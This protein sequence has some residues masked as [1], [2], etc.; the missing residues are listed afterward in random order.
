MEHS[1]STGLSIRAFA[2]LD[3]CT[4]TT[5]RR[6]ISGGKLPVFADGTI[7]ARHAGGEWRQQNR[8][9]EGGTS[10]G[11]KGGTSHAPRSTV[12]AAA[13]PGGEVFAEEADRFLNDVLAGRY[14]TLA[15]AERVKENALAA[16]H[17]L[18]ARRESGELVELEMAEAALFET[19]RTMRDAWLN[20]PVRV[21]PLIAAALGISADALAT[22]MS[23]HVHQQIADLGEP[24]GSEFRDDA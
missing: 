8:R 22:Q 5:V 4:H 3:G 13:D 19:T 11:T 16:K 17:L 15:E 9:A 1:S 7:D 24:D 2:K 21:A 10:R 20:W 12:P 14:R 6:A 23:E 18:A